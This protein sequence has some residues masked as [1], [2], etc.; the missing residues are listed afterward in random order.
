M[1]GTTAT[2]NGEVNLQFDGETLFQQ[3]PGITIASTPIGAITSTI[4]GSSF[5]SVNRYPGNIF[6]TGE[7]MYARNISQNALSR[8][9]VCYWSYNGANFG[10]TE[11]NVGIVQSTFMLGVVLQDI[12]P[13]G[14]GHFL[15]KGFVSIPQNLTSFGGAGDGEPIYLLRGTPGGVATSAN[16]AGSPG[17]D[18]YRCVGY[19][20]SLIGS[21]SGSYHVIRFDP[22]TD[23]IL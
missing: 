3:T 11:T 21:T 19:I 14:A 20:V 10:F 7:V 13:G 4:N 5:T 2:I 9:Q 15:L 22:S 23:Y 16:W 1:T 6:F 12:A 8:G 18:Y 17:N